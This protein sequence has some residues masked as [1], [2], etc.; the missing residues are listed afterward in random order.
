[1]TFRTVVSAEHVC[2]SES[3]SC[4]LIPSSDTAASS[5]ISSTFGVTSSAVISVSGED[6]TAK[7]YAWEECEEVGDSSRLLF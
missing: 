7:L 3:L 1:M 6:T 2:K 4:C 5:S